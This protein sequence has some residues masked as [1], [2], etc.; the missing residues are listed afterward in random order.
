MNDYL[1]VVDNLVHLW[2]LHLLNGQHGV[3][4][5]LAK[6]EAEPTLTTIRFHAGAHLADK[7]STHYT[8]IYGGCWDV[9]NLGY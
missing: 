3:V 7:G 9:G 1:C 8:H 2:L 5:L 6:H 4:V